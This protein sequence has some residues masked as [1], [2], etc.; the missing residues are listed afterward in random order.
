VRVCPY[1]VFE[2]GELDEAQRAALP[3]FPFRLKAWTHGWKQAFATSPDR[4]HGCGFCVAACP[5][6]AIKLEA[7][8]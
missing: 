7:V 1:G 4:C 8:R 2:L 6:R 5:E 3:A